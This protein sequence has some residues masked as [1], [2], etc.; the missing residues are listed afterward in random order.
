MGVGR[1]M[2]GALFHRVAAFSAREM[3]RFGTPSLI[4]RNTN[5]VQQVQIF[6]AGRADDHGVG[7]RSCASAA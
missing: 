7:A 5:D 4:T 1:D 3:N 2:R 6:V